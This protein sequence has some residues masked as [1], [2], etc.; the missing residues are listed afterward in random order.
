[1]L[2]SSQIANETIICRN[3]CIFNS[4]FLKN[5]SIKFFEVLEQVLSKVLLCLRILT[6]SSKVS[7]QIGKISSKTEKM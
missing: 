5:D 2:E 7:I 3:Y 4:R 6:K 1:M